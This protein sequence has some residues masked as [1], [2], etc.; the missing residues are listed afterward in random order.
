MILC[1]LLRPELMLYAVLVS[2]VQSPAVFELEDVGSGRHVEFTRLPA[3]IPI[4]IVR[5]CS[6][7][8]CGP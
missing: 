1:D 8:V 5:H 4:G 7:D 3:A 2:D 6:Q